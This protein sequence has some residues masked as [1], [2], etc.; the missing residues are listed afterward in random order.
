VGLHVRILLAILL[1]A[2]HGAPAS[3]APV[4]A[5]RVGPVADRHPE[6]APPPPLPVTPLPSGTSVT[7]VSFT[8]ASTLIPSG[9]PWAIQADAACHGEVI[10]TWT[11]QATGLGNATDLKRVFQDEA[12]KAGFQVMGGPADLFEPGRRGTHKT[13]DL[14]IGALVTG[15]HLRLCA[16][17]RPKGV[18][19]AAVKATGSLVMDVE[20]Q[21]YS[22]SKSQVLARFT[23][24]GG[25]RLA[26]QTPAA[27]A[28]LRQAAFAQ[29]TRALL[30]LEPFRALVTG[31]DETPDPPPSREHRRRSRL[32]P[33]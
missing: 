29:N 32:D 14:K 11:G 10:K 4:H 21:V 8:K 6:F 5:A 1:A 33:G 31:T 12:Q 20:W 30:A 7:P 26:V 22:K 3:A 23:T 16:G 13:T 24:R 9:T 27:G 17:P 18:R 15:L 28:V 25:D 19:A 2:G